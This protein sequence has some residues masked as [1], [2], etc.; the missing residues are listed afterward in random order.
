MPSSHLTPRVACLM[1]TL[2]LGCTTNITVSDLGAIRGRVVNASGL[3]LADV[4]VRAGE[5]RAVSAR[6]PQDVNQ[7]RDPKADEDNGRDNALVAFDYRDD[8]L[9]PLPALRV[10]R[11]FPPSESQD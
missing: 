6:V 9:G 11:K 2:L 7:D 10:L 3:P 4:E 5:A 8:E 1:T